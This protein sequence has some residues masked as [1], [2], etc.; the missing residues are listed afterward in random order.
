MNEPPAAK[1]GGG[2]AASPP[3]S[4]SETAT[5]VSSPTPQGAKDDATG[6]V[7]L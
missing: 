2:N 7:S 6:A 1:G 3:S 5:I 4:F